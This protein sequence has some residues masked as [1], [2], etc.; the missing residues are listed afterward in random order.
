MQSRFCHCERKVCSPEAVELAA[1]ADA[2]KAVATALPSPPP[3]AIAAATAAAAVAAPLSAEAPASP[4][5]T[6]EAALPSGCGAGRT[7]TCSRCA[8]R[9]TASSISFCASSKMSGC[10]L[11]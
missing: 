6:P 8:R 4:A 5:A 10:A 3:P 2:A 9:R 1:G 11:P 7:G